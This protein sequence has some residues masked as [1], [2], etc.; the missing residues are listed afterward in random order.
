MKKINLRSLLST[1]VTV[2]LVIVLFGI[3][4]VRLK[5]VDPSPTFFLELS[6]I[7]GLIVIIKSSWYNWAEEKKLKEDEDIK[8]AK[9]DYDNYVDSEVKDIYD[10]EEFLV[11]LNEENRKNYVKNKLKN[12]TEQNCKNYK[13]LKE[14]Y[15]KKSYSKVREI[16]SSDVKTR[17]DTLYLADAKNYQKTK[18]YL[19][20]I[21]TTTFTVIFTTIL[22]FIGFDKIFMSWANLFRYVTY[23]FT[24]AFT[25]ASTITT[26][27]RFTEEEVY[28]HLKR[29]QFIVDKYVNYKGGKNGN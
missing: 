25:M 1:I 14:K 5:L 10:F 19:Y 3:I 17:G 18:K 24:I 27:F 11:I 29:L 28:D 12:K 20:Q 15:E 13:K 7:I 4:F 16:K 2:L 26:A 22:A 23:L 21:I 8:K 6:A 9:R